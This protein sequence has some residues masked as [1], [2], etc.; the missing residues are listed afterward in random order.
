M[1]KAS[2]LRRPR[3]LHLM[4]GTLLCVAL[5]LAGT[6]GAADNRFEQAKAAFAEASAS[7]NG[8]HEGYDRAHALWLTL[9]QE[10]DLR[11]RYHIGIL[12]MFGL[13]KAQFDQGLAMQHVRAAAQAGYA[14]AQSYMGLVSE[15]G[16]GSLT[17]RGDEVAFGWWLKGAE[18]GHCAAVRR[19]VRA[20]SN[21]ELGLAADAE[22]AQGWARKEAG[23]SRN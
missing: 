16:D 5:A 21:G 11:A 7:G 12:H 20:Y 19:M 22:K 13:G 9:A 15:N 17:R 3:A 6:V 1:S 14:Q 4:R 8:E 18:G 2:S 10:G 23:C